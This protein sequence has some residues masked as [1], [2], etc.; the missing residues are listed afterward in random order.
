MQVLFNILFQEIKNICKYFNTNTWTQKHVYKFIQL[1]KR[2]YS[3]G[4]AHSVY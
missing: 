1:G 2:R 3:K 4:F